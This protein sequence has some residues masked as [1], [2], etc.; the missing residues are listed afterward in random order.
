MAGQFSGTHQSPSRKDYEYQA[1]SSKFPSDATGGVPT[2][3]TTTSHQKT[4]SQHTPLTK[5]R[6]SSVS[7]GYSSSFIAAASSSNQYKSEKY[8]SSA[9]SHLL[10][11]PL[12]PLM[13][14]SGNSE[15]G[16]DVAGFKESPR[17]RRRKERGDSLIADKR[18]QKTA[19]V[20]PPSPLKRS[21]SYSSLYRSSVADC[22]NFNN[23]NSAQGRKFL[24]RER[25]SSVTS[26]TLFTY[27]ETKNAS[28]TQ[29][30]EE[31][32]ISSSTS[33]PSIPA[34]ADVSATELPMHMDSIS[35]HSSSSPRSHR[36]SSQ[37]SSSHSHSDSASSDVISHSDAIS[38]L[39][40]PAPN[41]SRLKRFLKFIRKSS[42]NNSSQ[43]IRP[44]S[45]E[46]SR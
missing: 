15:E 19:G 35:I 12:P 28:K 42:K 41:E 18:N 37:A 23:N 33:I 44:T 3:T 27:G 22:L 46:F 30:S 38:P 17:A 10:S 39:E 7:S 43:H 31:S 24:H 1:S 14:D 25:S 6:S 32:G 16:S 9:R 45:Q 20:D 13:L 21:N 11:N 26:K 8:S 34:H 40:K 29:R 36:V 5:R 2:I 4:S